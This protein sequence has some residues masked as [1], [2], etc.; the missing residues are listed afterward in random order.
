MTPTDTEEWHGR[1]ALV[2]GGSTGIGLAIAEAYVAAGAAVW[3][4]RLMGAV[5]GRGFEDDVVDQTYRPRNDGSSLP[6]SS[7]I[8]SVYSS[9]TRPLLVVDVHRL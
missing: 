9:M 3:V 6:H 2:T 4:V 5:A 7:I 8:A 1:V